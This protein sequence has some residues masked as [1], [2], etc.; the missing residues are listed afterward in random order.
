MISKW[1]WMIPFMRHTPCFITNIWESSGCAEM[2][3]F[4][5]S[6]VLALWS[7]VNCSATILLDLDTEP[8]TALESPRLAIYNIPFQITPTKQQE[9]IDAI[10]GFISIVL[11]TRERNPSSVAENAFLR[12]SSDIVPF[13]R[14]IAEITKHASNESKSITLFYWTTVDTLLK[15]QCQ[16]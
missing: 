10:K 9:P 8:I 5:T 11:R 13:S 1:T 6:S 7:L 16:N 12:L 2:S 4:L 14:A 3:S 15:K